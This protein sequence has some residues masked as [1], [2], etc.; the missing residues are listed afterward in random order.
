MLL[1]V[2]NP[3]LSPGGIHVTLRSPPSTP[4]S[5]DS[6]PGILPLVVVEL[7]RPHELR[8]AFTANQSV[9]HYPIQEDQGPASW[10]TSAPTWGFVDS[11]HC[12]ASVSK[13]A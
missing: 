10:L 12:S 13:H 7:T 2:L 8:L 11:A 3:Y 9:C 6:R 5:L 4:L 1:L